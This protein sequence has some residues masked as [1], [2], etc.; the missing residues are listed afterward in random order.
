MTVTSRVFGMLVAVVFGVAACGGSS[1]TGG[2][3]GNPTS[4]SQTVSLSS[5]AS[6]VALPAVGTYT[7]SL[8]LPAGTPVGAALNT[9]VTTQQPAGLPAL[10]SMFEKDP[11]ALQIEGSPS[12]DLTVPV[13]I[14]FLQLTNS[15]ST[16]EVF[17][18][19]PGFSM[20]T[21]GTATFP[22][23]TYQSEGYDSANPSAGWVA[24][25][26]AVLVAPTLTFTGPQG[27]FTVA[28]GDTVTLALVAEQVAASGVVTLSP[29]SSAA[30]PFSLTP[31]GNITLT[32]VESGYSGTF[33][34]TSSAVGVA[35]VAQGSS[36]SLFTVTG[37]AAGTAQITVSDNA[38][39]S[40]IFY[41]S[42][43]AS[44]AASGTFTVNLPA[45]QGV[46]VAIPSISGGNVLSGTVTFAT[47]AAGN[48]YPAGTVVTV[49][50]TN[51]VPAGFSFAKP[52]GQEFGVTFSSNNTITTATMPALPS[53][54][55]TLGQSTFSYLD[56]EILL[57]LKAFDTSCSVSGG[58]TANSWV[59]AGQPV[60][61]GLAAGTPSG[62]DF[63]FGNAICLP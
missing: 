14:A 12:R 21:A 33:T 26:T 61:Q 16:A 51:A 3:Q 27:T 55:V 18:A 28:A 57:P 5:S 50:V 44:S 6:V 7:E 40:A 46:A 13:P 15:T 47:A 37:V 38:S 17:G 10:S 11:A 32:A 23:G 56:G 60:P 19:Y 53:L 24:V 59:I 58:G 54:S 25:G 39:H 2:Q 30:S 48:P 1:N 29:A 35:T 45:Q 43:A 20:T 9:T 36:A 22:S 42:V 31:G 62:Y 8:S 63:F 52:T 4:A 41:V 49:T 34:A